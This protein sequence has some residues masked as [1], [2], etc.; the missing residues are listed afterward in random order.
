MQVRVVKSSRVT[1]AH[2][3]GED[4]WQPTFADPWQDNLEDPWQ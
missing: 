4:P 2:D 1:A 3:S